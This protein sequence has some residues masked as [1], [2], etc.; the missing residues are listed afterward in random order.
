MQEINWIALYSKAMD[1]AV[2]TAKDIRST[3]SG[4]LCCI[5]YSKCNAQTL[6]GVHAYDA[7]IPSGLRNVGDEAIANGTSRVDRHTTPYSANTTLANGQSRGAVTND[8]TILYD[9]NASYP[10][11]SAVTPVNGVPANKRILGIP[12]KEAPEN[13]ILL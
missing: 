6:I 10:S 1:C 13:S 2:F 11:S 12:A 9:G 3:V 8:T 5:I 4:V 7:F